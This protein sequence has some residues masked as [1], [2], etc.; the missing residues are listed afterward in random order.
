MTSSSDLTFE[1]VGVSLMMQR[2][3]PWGLA[4]TSGVPG[5]YHALRK[6][7]QQNEQNIPRSRAN[8]RTT[9]TF[10]SSPYICK[11]A[12]PALKTPPVVTFWWLA[13][14]KNKLV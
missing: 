3:W 2:P 4:E 5:I 12:F 13:P 10:W 9:L 7:L 6:V 14:R 1:A 8:S 11:S